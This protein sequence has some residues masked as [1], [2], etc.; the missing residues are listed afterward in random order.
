MPITYFNKHGINIKQIFVSPSGFGS[1]FISA[2]N[3]L[4]ACGRNSSGQLGIG[5][6]D[7]I[8]ELMLVSDLENKFVIDIKSSNDY[9]IAIC[10]DNNPKFMIIITNWAR[11]YSLPQDIIN[12]IIL[13]MK[14]TN[15]F[16]TTT[17][18]GTGHLE[19]DEIV[20]KTGWNMVNS[21]KDKNIIKC[22]V[23]FRHSMFLE[24]NGILW[25]CGTILSGRLGLGL[26]D[27]EYERLDH[28]QDHYLWKP[29]KIS[30]FI[31]EKIVITDV[32]CGQTHNIA[33]G[34][35]GDV[36]SWGDNGEGQC[37]HERDDEEDNILNKPK[38]IESVK[39]FVIDYIDCGYC[40]SYVRT[41][42]KKHYLFGNDTGECITYNDEDNICIPFRVDQIIKSHC[43][44]KEIIEIKLGWYNT[45]VAVSV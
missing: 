9:S 3:K 45:K 29:T 33:L 18:S 13:F 32:K 43:N 8:Y 41:V 20:N 38:L 4:Y 15:V 11:L 39:E 28:M 31:K 24:E 34:M 36:Y 37:G 7:N 14:I 12:L 25:T 5:S 6:K 27:D 30:Y 21:L 10:S 40:H 26:K 23:G 35:N 19:G 1:F 16:A 42:D 22:A 2:D 44:A 17:E